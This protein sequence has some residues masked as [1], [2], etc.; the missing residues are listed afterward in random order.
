MCC[1]QGR[2]AGT[3]VYDPEDEQRLQ[4]AMMTAGLMPADLESTIETAGVAV[5]DL[6]L[7]KRF[8]VN[9]LKGFTGASFKYQYIIVHERKLRLR[10]TKTTIFS[11]PVATATSI[12]LAISI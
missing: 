12:I 3:F 1:G 9:W 6:A 8:N 7:M 4:L 10:S 5:I 2:F 11:I